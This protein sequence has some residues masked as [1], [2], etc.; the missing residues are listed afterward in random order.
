MTVD[1][2]VFAGGT[3]QR[4][5]GSD[6]PKQFLE[7]AGKPIIIHTIEQFAYHNEINHITVVCIE[8]WVEALKQ[9]LMRKSYCNLVDVIPGGSTGQESIFNGLQHIHNLCAKTDESQSIV[10]IHDGVRPLVDKKTISSCIRSVKEQG[11]AITVVPAIE[12]IAILSDNGSISNI[13]NRADCVMARAPQGFW[14]EDILKAHIRA[15]KENLEFIDSLSMMLHYGH[16]V[17]PVEGSYENIK[18]TTPID[19]FTCKALMDMR[20]YGGLWE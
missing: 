10:L 4:M 1:A 15:R 19:Y 11:S 8:S 7:I 14:L 9:L 2:L 17:V 13:V 6:R 5:T 16:A 3:G 12:T 18:V 20:D